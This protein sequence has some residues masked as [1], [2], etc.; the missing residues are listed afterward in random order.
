[1]KNINIRVLFI[2]S[3]GGRNLEKNNHFQFQFQFG[4]GGAT[5]Q[6]ALLVTA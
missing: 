3:V 5:F 6:V 1:M 2:Q 4:V